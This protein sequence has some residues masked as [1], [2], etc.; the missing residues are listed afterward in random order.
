MKDIEK[1]FEEKLKDHKVMPPP[2]S[3]DKL[4]QQMQGGTKK[5]MAPIFSWRIAT[6]VAL[7]LAVAFLVRDFNVHE[8][9][10]AATN[11][12][13][14][15]QTQ[16][17]ERH[18]DDKSIAEVAK[19]DLLQESPQAAAKPQPKEVQ[20]TGSDMRKIDTPAQQQTIYKQAE[21]SQAEPQ[22]VLT[23]IPKVASQ[24]LHRLNDVTDGQVIIAS[25]PSFVATSQKH[26]PVKIVYT[27]DAPAE[28]ENNNYRAFAFL[29]NLK[30]SGLSFSEL[31]QA[32]DELVAKA[33]SSIYD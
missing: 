5:G 16:Q 31:R 30:G 8:K 22:P 24:Q 17:T 9:T 19:G 7:L 12:V 6:A 33:F 27:G 32:K 13:Q 18:Q 4:Q 26:M 25:A 10:Q 29:D 1:F 21:V 14:Q 15:Q 3:W 11:I 23:H 2:Q 20:K 28:D